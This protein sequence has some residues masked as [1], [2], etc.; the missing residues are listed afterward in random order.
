[1]VSVLK[2]GCGLTRTEDSAMLT[3]AEMKALRNNVGS[4]EFERRIG[5]HCKEV[6]YFN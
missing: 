3:V 2:R 6:F 1:M 4:E 5:L